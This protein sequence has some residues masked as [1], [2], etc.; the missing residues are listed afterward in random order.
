MLACL[1][2]L[3]VLRVRDCGVDAQMNTAA[4]WS[5]SEAIDTTNSKPLRA[6]RFTTWG[7]P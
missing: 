1:P 6:P 7:T 3:F 4:L 5:E 2:R